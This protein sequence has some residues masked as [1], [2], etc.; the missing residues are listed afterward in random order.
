[1][2]KQIYSNKVKT[3]F[4][5]TLICAPVSV[6]FSYFGVW[7]F[8]K[9]MGGSFIFLPNLFVL[10]GTT[11]VSVACVM[12]SALS[13]LVF[14]ARVSPMQAI[15]NI[16]LSRKMKRKKI[17]QEKALYKS[18][19]TVLKRLPTFC[20]RKHKLH[21]LQPAVMVGIGSWSNLL[22]STIVHIV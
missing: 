15:R 7:L 8:A 1:M 11:V 16:D 4:I 10:I 22:Y 13:P 12:L 17:K 14:A 21:T 3:A 18:M 2:R 5:I 20:C 9:I 6:A 19:N